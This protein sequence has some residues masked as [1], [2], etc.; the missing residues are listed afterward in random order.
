VLLRPRVAASMVEVGEA[1][2][3]VEVA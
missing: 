1:A 2:S 3:M